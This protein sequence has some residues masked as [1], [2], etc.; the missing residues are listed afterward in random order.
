MFQL[1]TYREHNRFRPTF[2]KSVRKKPAP[3]EAV[4]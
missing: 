1:G 2:R 3:F 4:E